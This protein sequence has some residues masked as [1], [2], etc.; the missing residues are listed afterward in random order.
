MLWAS[1]RWE[2][3]MKMRIAVFG[4]AV[5]LAV[6]GLAIG[7][8][9]AADAKK[10]WDVRGLGTFACSKYTAAPKAKGDYVNWMTGFISAYNWLQADTYDVAGKMGPNSFTAFFDVYCKA[11]PKK[12]IND[13]AMS[14]VNQ[15]YPKRVKTKP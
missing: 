13:A 8:A 3:M 6:T 10:Q 11:N 7:L 14:F 12:T 9:G 1:A 2:Q 4:A 15:F 5:A